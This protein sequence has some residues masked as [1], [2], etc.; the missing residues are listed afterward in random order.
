MVAQRNVAGLAR[1]GRQAHAHQIGAHRS[2]AEVSVSIATVR[3]ARGD[4]GLQGLH[5]LQA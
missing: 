2:S 1:A 3:A 5:R 4:P